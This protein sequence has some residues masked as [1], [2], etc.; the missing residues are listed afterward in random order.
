MN[1]KDK[2][3]FEKLLSEYLENN[4]QLLEDLAKK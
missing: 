2:K 3:K 4:K 1:D